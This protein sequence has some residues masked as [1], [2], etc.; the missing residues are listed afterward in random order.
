MKAP[1]EVNYYEVLG[2]PGK[3]ATPEQIK[4]AYRKMAM[5]HHPDRNIDDPEGATEKM[6]EVTTANDVLSDPEKKKVYDNFGMQGLKMMDNMGPGGVVPP[7][8]AIFMTFCA[9]F[10]TVGFF[11]VFLI[12]LMLRVDGVM[13]TSWFVVFIPL[14]FINFLLFMLMGLA[15]T[16]RKAWEK[17]RAK[18]TMAGAAVLCVWVAAP[19]LLCLNLDDPHTM[20]WWLALLPWLV[21]EFALM[22]YTLLKLPNEEQHAV[23][24]ARDETMDT[25]KQYK[26][27]MVLGV[28]IRATTILL[29]MLQITN[30]IHISWW[31]VLMPQL[32]YYGLYVV[33]CQTCGALGLHTIPDALPAHAGQEGG[34][35]KRQALQGQR[36]AVGVASLLTA[37]TLILLIN[38]LEDPDGL[39]IWVVFLLPLL[40]IGGGCCCLCCMGGIAMS[41]TDVEAAMR[42]AAAEEEAAQ[43]EAQRGGTGSSSMGEKTHGDKEPIFQGEGSTALQ[44][45]V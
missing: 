24:V 36:C 41:G 21:T 4:K 42:A 17:E 2:L 39:S 34:N 10:S 8:V 5:K 19:I 11:L 38:K 29:V 22:F 43:A 18:A 45:P 31:L 33:E 1:E 32:L 9:I 14:F 28:F 30:S 12:L 37:V 7:V 44:S 23:M 3:Q 40:F 16:N 15:L 20:S 26:F 25:H 6:I 27:H 13:D 35:E